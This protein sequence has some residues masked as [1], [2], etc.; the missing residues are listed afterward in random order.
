MRSIFFSTGLAA[1]F[2][3]SSLLSGPTLAENYDGSA[4]LI[5][6]SIDT[7]QCDAEGECVSGTAAHVNLPQ[8]F[9]VNFQE[10][11]VRARRVDGSERSTRIE[12]LRHDGGHMILQGAE[13]GIGWS[14]LIDQVSG[15]MTITASGDGEAF[16]VFGACTTD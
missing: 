6:A 13:E 14:V 10:E 4:P 9:R 11:I 2:L 15:Q 1:S 8:F 5:C 7:V 12:R 3:V 16:V